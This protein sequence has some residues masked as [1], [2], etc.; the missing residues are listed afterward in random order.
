[1]VVHAIF[2][3]IIKSMEMILIWDFYTNILDIPNPDLQNWFKIH[4][5][6]IV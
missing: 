6:N 4:I 1:M 2:L 3:T 5:N